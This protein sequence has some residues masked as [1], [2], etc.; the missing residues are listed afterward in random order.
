MKKDPNFKSKFFQICF[1]LDWDKI[2]LINKSR[3]DPN[4]NNV[5]IGLDKECCGILQDNDSGS[6]Y[7]L[8]YLNHGSQNGY[9]MELSAENLYRDHYTLCLALFL[10]DKYPNIDS[11]D[12]F[13][14]FQERARSYFEKMGYLTIS[15]LEHI[16]DNSQVIATGAKGIIEMTFIDKLFYYIEYMNESNSLPF[17][18]G[19]SFIY[20]MLNQRTNAIKMGHSKYR[21]AKFREKT[22]QSQEPEV[23]LITYWVAP[24]PIEKELHKEF[25]AKRIRGEWFLLTFNDLKAIKEKMRLYY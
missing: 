16:F 18:T 11:I 13:N 10:A 23:D 9:I 12:I 14:A 6:D 15:L 2:L 8:I 3:N 19:D 1:I 7:S 25:K 17:R 4:I 24:K 21:P 5:V 20:L 22:L